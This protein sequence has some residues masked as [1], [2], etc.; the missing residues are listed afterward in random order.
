MRTKALL[1]EPR[2][3]LVEIMQS[4]NFGRIE[5]LIFRHGDPVFDRMPRIIRDLKFGGE[6]GPR[7]E[8]DLAD[9]SLNS[10][11]IELFDYF[12]HAEKGSI[13]VLEIMHGLP[14]RMSVVEVG[15]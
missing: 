15:A 12:D 13:D 8:R 4:I 10:K 9:F 14:F 5:G 1:S 6:N 11:V 3:R 2:K 7:P